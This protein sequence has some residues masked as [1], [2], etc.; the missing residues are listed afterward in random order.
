MLRLIFMAFS[1]ASFFALLFS[2]VRGWVVGDDC[3]ERY[4]MHLINRYFGLGC[5]DVGYGCGIEFFLIV[6]V[7]G[8]SFLFIWLRTDALS[9]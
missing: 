8:F 9:K 7:V 1:G 5:I 6:F 2:M 4:C 3:S